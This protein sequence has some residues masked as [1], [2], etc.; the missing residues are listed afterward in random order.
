MLAE[1]NKDLE[2]LNMKIEL[3]KS[4]G[5]ETSLIKK[6]EILKLNSSIS[7]DMI[8]AIDERKINPLKATTQ[9]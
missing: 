5:I 2:K 7:E 1:N 3:E 8:Y 6:D 4:A 9:I